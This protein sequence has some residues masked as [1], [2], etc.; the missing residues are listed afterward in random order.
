[1]SAPSIPQ[2]VLVTGGAGY[3]GSHVCKA[4][5]E[6]GVQP[7]CLDTLE[8][9]HDWAVRWG[10]LERGDVG[11]SRFLED[12]FL[13]HRPKVVIHLAGYIEVGE[14]VAQPERYLSNNAAKSEVL[15][16]AAV[17]HKVEG[18]ISGLMNRRPE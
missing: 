10:V 15:I 18:S 1:M 2:P 17:R 4:L 3:I 16:G 7:I 13:R 6:A 9:G 8:K 12:V 11:D 5:A 14:S